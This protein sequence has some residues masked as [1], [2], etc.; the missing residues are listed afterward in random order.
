MLV[1]CVASAFEEIRRALE[2]LIQD[3]VADPQS[4][5]EEAEEEVKKE[6]DPLCEPDA[7]PNGKRATPQEGEQ[8]QQGESLSRPCKKSRSENSH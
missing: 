7:E 1:T 4:A 5:E 8:Q 3:Y 6:V 2:A